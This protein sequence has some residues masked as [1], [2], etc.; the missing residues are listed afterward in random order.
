MAKVTARKKTLSAK[1]QWARTRKAKAPRKPKWTVMVFMGANNLPTEADLSDEAAADIKE[2]KQ[3]GSNSSLNIFVQVHGK[4]G[5]TREHIGK[6]KAIPVPDAEREATNGKALICFMRWALETAKHRKADHSML[7]LWGHAYRFGIA[8]AD[9]PSGVDALD[10][11]ELADVLSAFQEKHRR[12]NSKDY[13]VDAPKLDVIAFDACDLATI[14]MAYQMRPFAKYLLASQ[15]AIPL[16]GWPY[17]LTLGRLKKPVGPP[18]TPVELGT[19]IVRQ[20]CAHYFEQNKGKTTQQA[21]SMTLLDLSRAEEI[22]EATETLARKLAIA[23]EDPDEDMMVSALFE[24]S[25]ASAGQPFIDVSDLCLNLSR[26]SSDNAV[27]NAAG[28]LGDLLSRPV[29]PPPSQGNGRV[30]PTPR[31]FIVEHG[32][33]ANATAKLHGVSLF[34]PHV[35]GDADGAETASDLYDKFVF[36]RKTLWSDL[37]LALAQAR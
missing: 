23:M 30:D 34:A 25:Q 2:M 5:V 14:E 20:F 32:R 33:N 37:I 18:M 13:Q 27:R 10:F 28:T 8:R 31:P 11:A 12:Q 9:T 21:V 26:Y 4:R 36:S 15:I 17:N 6:G 22:F 1:A 19:F 16:P 29:P 7:V 24:Q 35:L 3:V